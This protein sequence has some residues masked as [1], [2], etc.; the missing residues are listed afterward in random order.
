V[1]CSDVSSAEG[2]RYDHSSS[3]SPCG[4]D[5]CRTPNLVVIKVRVLPSRVEGADDGFVS[6][7]QR[8]KRRRVVDVAGLRCETVACF[9]LSGFGTIAV[10]TCPRSSASLSNAEPTKPVAPN[11][12]TFFIPSSSRPHR[13]RGP[14]P[15][16]RGAEWRHGGR[17]CGE[18]CLELWMREGGSVNR[19]SAQ[20]R[21]GNC[22]RGS[23]GADRGMFVREWMARAA[24]FTFQASANGRRR[25]GDENGC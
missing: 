12:A 24:A 2:L 3:G 5:R 25:G 4:D 7:D 10:T 8:R 11:R 6:S 1:R 19:H 18:T 16:E 21:R 9:N 14:R 20:R 23:S 22:G 15:S 13:C 17:I